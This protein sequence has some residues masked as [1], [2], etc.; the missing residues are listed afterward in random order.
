MKICGKACS[1]GAL[2]AVIN[3]RRRLSLPYDQSAFSTETTRK[4]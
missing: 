1:A 4:V 3:P 2:A